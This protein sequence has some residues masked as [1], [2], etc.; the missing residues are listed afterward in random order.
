MEDN[1]ML[2][3]LK[4]KKT[5]T[6]YPTNLGKKWEETE[7]TQLLDELNKNIP[8]SEIAILHNR[9]PGGISARLRVIAYNMYTNN[10]PMEKIIEATKL[11]IIQINDAIQKRE[12]HP[13]K[14]TKVIKEPIN[15]LIKESYYEELKIDI[16]EIKTELSNLKSSIQEFVEM[17]KAVYEF[18]DA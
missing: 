14:K 12:E 6:D 11:S 18:E 10:I 16:R 1:H 8:I 13:S 7:E 15:K 9:T 5:D 3:M 4:T 2:K 17:M